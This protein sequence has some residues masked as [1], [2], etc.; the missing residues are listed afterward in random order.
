MRRSRKFDRELGFYYDFQ[1][2]LCL[3]KRG[4]LKEEGEKNEKARTVVLY[5]RSKGDFVMW[6]G[7]KKIEIR[8][9]ARD[10]GAFQNFVWPVLKAA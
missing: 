9:H 2:F 5:P 10:K 6:F 3:R 8:N 1:V 4:F 7:G